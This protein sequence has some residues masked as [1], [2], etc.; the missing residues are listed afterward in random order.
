MAV[1]GYNTVASRNLIRAAQGML[2]H[3]QPITVL[4]DFGTQREMPQNSTDTL[5]FRRTLP[6]GAVAAG[7]NIQN[8]GPAGY[9]NTPV[10]AANSYLL[11]E[12]V[13][14]NSQS[15]TF[16]D[17]SVQLQQYGV[18]FKF[19]SKTEL[20]YEDDIPGEMTKLTGET[21]AEVLELVRYGVVKAG[22]VVLYANGSSRSAVNTPVT[23][24]VLRKAARVLESNR[25]K[26]VT[27]RLAPGVNF[28]TRA[29]QPAYVV[30]C[31]TDAVSDIRNLPGFTRVEEYGSFKPIHDRE[32]GSV[33]DFR[34]I[35]SPLFAPFAAA[36]ASTLNGMVSVANANVDVYPLI[37]IA[38][39]CWGQVALKGFNAI[40]PI[41]LKS[42]QT[43]HANPLGQF[44][45]V[46]AS[47]WF[48]AVRLNEAWMAR[49]EVGVTN[50]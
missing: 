32:F 21:M 11:S 43:N 50:L 47:T 41:V 31:H 33:E 23:L 22:S 27:S 39:D 13:T 12:G 26:R 44:G 9:I 46:G 5:V 20:L 28:A 1:Q 45:Y 14:P 35:S 30:F 3:A 8:G 10:I 40:K 2:E 38:E 48:N 7:T 18:L 24:N 4:G 42:S 17:V 16:Q 15:I 37:L 19:S 36:G 34:F 49:V 29:V 25:A 6:L